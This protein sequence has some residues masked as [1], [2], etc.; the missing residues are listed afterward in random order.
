VYSLKEKK[1]GEYKQNCLTTCHLP[2]VKL[3]LDTR[4]VRRKI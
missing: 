2:H 3:P 4:L 1:K